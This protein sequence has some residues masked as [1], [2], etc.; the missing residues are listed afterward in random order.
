MLN[1]SALTG[2]CLI[3]G[4]LALTSC[5]YENKTLEDGTETPKTK[6][7]NFLL[8]VADDLGYSDLGVF[9]GEI[10]TPNIDQL[11]TSGV[12]LTNFH[13]ASTCSPTRSMLLSG[14]DNHIAG[15][16]AMNEAKRMMKLPGEVLASP[17]YAGHLNDRV[18]ALPEV[19]N[20]SG[21]R[22]YMAGKWHLGYEDNQSPHA[23]GFEKT[24]TLLEG[25]AGHLSNMNAIPFHKKKHALYRENGESSAPPED[26]YSTEFYANTLI[27]YLKEDKDSDKPFFGYLAFT[28][29]HWPLQAPKESIARF[30]GKYDE[31]YEV[32][33]ERRIARLKELGLIS[34]DET[35]QD[36]IDAEPWDSLSS[37]EQQRYARAMEIYAAMVSDLDRYVGEVIQALKDMGEYDN[38]VIFFMSDNGAEAGQLDWAPKFDEFYARCCDPSIDNMGAA[39]SFVLYDS[40]WARVSGAPSRYFKSYTTQGGI[41]SPAIIYD[42]R[43]DEAKGRYDEFLSVMDIMPTFLDLAGIEHPGSEFQGREVVPMKGASMSSILDGKKQSIHGP[44]YV[45]GWE[46]H[47]HRALRKG[48]WKITFSRPPLGDNTWKLYDLSSD[49]F[50]HHDLSKKHPEK[51]TEMLADWDNYVE[52][53]GVYVPE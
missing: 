3:L 26:F 38:T 22:T 27:Q 16:G 42:P 32:F 4:F 19:L 12:Q 15:V 30:K 7:P 11:A 47:Y 46:L 17:G 25:G 13:T 28:A 44:D 35:G 6:Q 24:F 2:I 21:Y 48:N 52:E 37:E 40:G 18:A 8:I 39:N 53:N 45:M 1:K 31:G 41:L 14:T 50:E 49:P 33:F 36:L 34:E 23:R 20:A 5:S 10:G 29:P 9:G 43:S 51:M